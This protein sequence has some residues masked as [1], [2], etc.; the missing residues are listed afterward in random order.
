MTSGKSSG[1]ILSREK[2]LETAMTALEGKG[3]SKFSLDALLESMPVGKGSFYYHFR[4]REDFLLA[5]IEY[6][7]RHETQSVIDVLE[8]LPE[9]TSAEDKLWELMCVIYENKYQRHDLL[10]RSLTLEF[11]A[12]RKAVAK[13]DQKR[14][15][16]VSQLFAEMG[17]TGDELEM[18]T[19]TFVTAV[20]QEKMIFHK[21]PLSRYERQLKLRHAFF[22]RP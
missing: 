7:D 21:V 20:S 5:L 2:W 22:V 6:W 9:D 11:P 13:V 19:V 15:D 10:I 4:S 16:K 1:K 12:I 8:A 18:R 17:F 3:K 14:I